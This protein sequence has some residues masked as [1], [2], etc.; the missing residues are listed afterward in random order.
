MVE[1][2]PRRGRF[3]R[4]DQRREVDLP[5]E[6]GDVLGCRTKSRIEAA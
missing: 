5:V 4:L 6:T 2:P 1:V 3:D